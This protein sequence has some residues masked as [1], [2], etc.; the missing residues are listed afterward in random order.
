MAYQSEI[1]LR[2]KVIDAELKALEKRIER[3]QNPFGPSGARKGAAD[4]Q[5]RE[6]LRIEKE[7]LDFAKRAEDDLERLR[8]AKA[9]NTQRVKQR[10]LQIDRASRI[11]AAQDVAR[12]EKTLA[13]ENASFRENLALGA[14]F[15]L[16]FGGGIGAVGGGVL[17]AVAGRG[18]GGFGLQILFSALGQQIDAFFAGVSE[19]ATT[20]A[21]S[22]GGTTETLDALGEAG[23]RVEQSLIDQVQ[24]LEDAG[25]AVAAYD[26]VQKELT[27][28]SVSYTHLTLPTKRI[29]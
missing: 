2:V 25:R 9:R 19:A 18:G 7:R 14:G 20:V 21:S 13:K 5:A 4:R 8:I 15:P 27:A 16:L 22:L 12:A 11:K 10:L 17:G 3:V 26:A 6:N 24:S 28:T 23:I 29:V 1:E